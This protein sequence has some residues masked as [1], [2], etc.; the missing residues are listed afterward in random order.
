MSALPASR[1]FGW[2]LTFLL[3]GI[4][5]GFAQTPPAEPPPSGRIE[6]SAVVESASPDSGHSAE[7][8]R[9]DLLVR[10]AKANMELAEAELQ[11]ALEENK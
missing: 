9:Y 5:A 4:P 8:V 1:V 6:P 7:A 11:Y 10:Y 2:I 3:G